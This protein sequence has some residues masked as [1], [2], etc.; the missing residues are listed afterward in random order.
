[1]LVGRYL[2]ISLCWERK[3]EGRKGKEE[4]EGEATRGGQNPTIFSLSLNTK[5]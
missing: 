3:G 2:S 5:Q 1:M 4:K